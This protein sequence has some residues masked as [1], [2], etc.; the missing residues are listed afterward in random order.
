MFRLYGKYQKTYEKYARSESGRKA[1][2]YQKQYL[3]CVLGGFREPEETTLQRIAEPIGSAG[4]LNM[5]ISE[6]VSQS[7]LNNGNFALKKKP[8][9]RFRGAVRAVIAMHR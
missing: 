7:D 4:I 2:V 3:L 6:A 9:L 8:I 1:L 5:S